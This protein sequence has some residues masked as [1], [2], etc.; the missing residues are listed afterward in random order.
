MC[1]KLLKPDFNLLLNLCS[2]PGCYTSV[3]S[4]SNLQFNPSLQ[5]KQS[6]Q[7]HVSYVSSVLLCHPLLSAE[8][9]TSKRQQMPGN[10]QHKLK[11]T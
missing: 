4:K 1:L 11:Q 3:P 7:R 6:Q 2:M 10:P 8:T 9:H 5:S